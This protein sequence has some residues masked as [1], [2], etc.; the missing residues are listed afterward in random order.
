VLSGSAPFDRNTG[1]DGWKQGVLR[2]K[3]G[4]LIFGELFTNQS[5]FSEVLAHVDGSGKLDN[6][7]IKKFMKAKISSSQVFMDKV[8]GSQY[9]GPVLSATDAV[10]GLLKG[11]GSLN[12]LDACN[13]G[14]CKIPNNKV[15]VYTLKQDGG[16]EVHFIALYDSKV[17]VGSGTNNLSLSW[18][19]FETE[20]LK[21]INHYV[22]AK[23]TAI[24]GSY[25][26]FS[27]NTAG[28]TAGTA[29]LMMSGITDYLDTI[30]RLDANNGGQET[31]LT[32][33]LK[34]L[35]A[36]ANAYYSA[37]Q[38]A[39][40]AKSLLLQK[41]SDSTTASGKDDAQAKKGLEDFIDNM[42]I[43]LNKNID[44]RVRSLQY[45][46]LIAD[47]FKSINKSIDIESQKR[48]Y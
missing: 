7:A 9:K 21:S 38:I 11:F 35:L 13:G 31:S 8:G 36:E 43:E 47:T 39:M 34:M 45:S 42:S 27:A 3:L 46:R 16:S 10:T 4:R 14:S 19:G 23:V 41:F 2:Y 5:A 37:K 48:M 40:A 26:S 44:E 33:G 15:D 30:V 22:S 32:F 28:T 6:E 24:S 29:P 25:T 12:T 20:S 17:A 1:T 18:E